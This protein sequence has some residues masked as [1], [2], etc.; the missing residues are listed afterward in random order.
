MSRAQPP[1]AVLV[2]LSAVGPLALNMFV[3]SMPGLAATFAADYGTVQLTLSLYLIG[4]AVSQLAYGPLSD[5]FGRRPLMLAGIG[6]FLVGT[7]IALLAQSIGM[8][9]V[10]RLVQ[11]IGG[12]AGLVLSRAA[13]RDLFD[14]E[15]SASVI[16][17]ITMVMV[18]APMVAPLIGG[19][20][21]QWF[22]WRANFWLV[23]A[24]AVV[25]LGFAVPLLHET[26]HYRQPLPG[27]S[28]MIGSYAILL[29]SPVYRAHIAL[30]GFASGAFF[31]FLGAAPF[32][33]I[34]LMGHPPSDYGRWFALGAAGYMAGNFASSRLAVRVGLCRLIQAGM[35]F[36]AAGA[37]L[38]L[39]LAL[40]GQMTLLALFGP[41]AMIAIGNGLVLPS[42]NAGALSVD[43]RRAGAASGLSGFMQMGLG[44]GISTLAGHLV[45][46]SA[47]PLAA[48]MAVSVAI[49]LLAFHALRRANRQAREL[50]AR[51]RP[52]LPKAA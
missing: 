29:R 42:G 18:V 2:A 22:G 28:G 48:I 20:L 35:G 45:V 40:A 23:G 49:S 11:A 31:A 46:D 6:L 14:R 17:T 26:N 10:G 33:V 41:M 43:R 37:A 13:V 47:L 36:M 30:I 5:R 4:L 52:A 1:I 39:T 25:V 34:D 24:F 21:D 38:M 3:P 8:L 44:A 9:I 50:A 7:L 27:L 12:C 19:Y 51:T 32:V 16:A 15:R